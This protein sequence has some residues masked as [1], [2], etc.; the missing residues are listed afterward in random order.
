MLE[1]GLSLMSSTVT[2]YLATGNAPQRRGNLANSRSPGAGSFACRDG[3]LSLGVNEE[4]H[5][6]A[7]AKGLDC[8]AWLSD[9]RFAE[10]GARKSHAGDLVTL[11]ESELQKK[12]A[13][14]WEVILQAA[15]VPCARLRALPDALDSE[16]VRQRGFVQALPDGTKVPTLPFQMN[17]SGPFRLG[18]NAPRLG[19]D[20]DMFDALLALMKQQS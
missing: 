6:V 12:S 15:G 18:S 14:E 7:L 2:D 10:R 20:N 8:E 13:G 1:T 5:F 9:P 3:V 11:I 19:Q 17:K 4:A 16:Q